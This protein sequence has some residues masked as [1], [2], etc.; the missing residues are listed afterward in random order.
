MADNTPAERDRTVDFLRA[1]CIA[2]V[3]L[4]HWVFSMNHW[5]D[6]G[7]L[8]MPNPLHTVPGSWALTWVLQ[9]MPLFFVIG[10]FANRAAW[11]GA[12]R[13]A[14]GRG[15]RASKRAFIAG[16]MRRM[17]VPVV[18]MAATWAV[19]D[20][21]LTT[22]FGMASVLSWGFAVFMPLWFLGIY[23][24]ITALSPFTV[25]AFGRRRFASVAAIGAA[26]VA[27]DIGRFALELP[28]VTFIN[29]GLVFL[30]A[31]QLGHAWH[32]GL[33][34]SRA[35]RTSRSSGPAN[36]GPLASPALV[37]V[38]PTV[39]AGF[40]AAAGVALLALS[41]TFGPYS[42]SMVAVAGED[43]SNMNPST[44]PVAA[45]AIFQLG[46]AG[47]AKPALERFTQRRRVWKATIAV[48]AVAMSVF[49]WHMTALAA[50]MGLATAVGITL[51]SE[52]T[53]GWWLA[54]PLFLILPGIVLA[55][56]L[57]IFARLELPRMS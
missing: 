19:L 42:S 35:H 38:S 14:D 29:T 13:A 52:P 5:N 6:S 56:L 11:T 3:V 20:L 57:A 28:G 39:R 36:S 9:V 46:L 34:A 24:V 4:W 45:L 7:A 8:A 49:T 41:T 44:A 47:L 40:V 18:V 10:G 12:Q 2:V 22:A 32:A 15:E 54:R 23:L 53:L 21:V 50:V 16:R 48:N 17:G 25:E 31:H 33:F 51:G 43:I 30:F 26:V 37:D 27:A 55:S 1:V